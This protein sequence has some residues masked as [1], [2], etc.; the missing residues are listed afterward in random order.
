MSIPAIIDITALFLLLIFVIKGILRGFV[1]EVL[2]LF[3]HIGGFVLAWRYA[4]AVGE[5]LSRFFA[6][7]EEVRFVV[8]LVAIFVAIN[9][10]VALAAR[11]IKGFLRLARL[12][13]LDYILGAVVGAGKTFLICLIFYAVAASLVPVVPPS[14]LYESRTMALTA[15][16]WPHVSAWLVENGIVKID[17][18]RTIPG[19]RGLF[20]DGDI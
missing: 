18:M 7:G 9:L 2:T 14:W 20:R 13:G 5:E 19:G 17:Q 4:P 6:W 10:L 8:S 3:G 12:S 16:A 11:F 1:I 15:K